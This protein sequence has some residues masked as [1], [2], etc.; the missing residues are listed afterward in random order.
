MARTGEAMTDQMEAFR[1][2]S[3][4]LAG[5]FQNCDQAF[6]DPA[7]FVHLRLWSHPVPLF[8]DSITYF[9]EQA[10]A[11]FSQPPYRQ[12][13]LR[14][15]RPESAVSWTAEYYA[16]KEPRAF[17]GAAQE[18]DRLKKL[19]TDCLQPLTGSRLEIKAKPESRV[20]RL[21]ARQFPGERCQFTV[22]GKVKWVELAFDALSPHPQNSAQAEF[23]MYD[24]GID[25]D[26][27]KATWGATNGPFKL[28]K[29]EDLSRLLPTI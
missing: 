24:K 26:T 20:T 22:N 28:L 21:Q 2:L 18:S 23:W 4:C 1:Q 15:R 25:P 16:L 13:L 6:A 27:G 7:W 19:T 17:Q 9:I 29:V 12:R 8:S 5:V 14:L 3:R 11:A 10:S